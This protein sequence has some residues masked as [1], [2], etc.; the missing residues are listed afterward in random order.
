MDWIDALP[1]F[2]KTVKRHQQGQVAGL[3]AFVDLK[4][5]RPEWGS[6]LQLNIEELIML[7]TTVY[8]Y[9]EDEQLVERWT[10]MVRLHLLNLLKDFGEALLE[11]E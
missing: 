10:Q 8:A 6:Y 9:V 3:E 5:R 7:L 2:S 1:D 11:K 4:K